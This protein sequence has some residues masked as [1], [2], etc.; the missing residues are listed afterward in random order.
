MIGIRGRRKEDG[1]KGADHVRLGTG[2]MHDT[3]NRDVRQRTGT[4][5][6]KQRRK[7]GESGR[8]TRNRDV[9]QGT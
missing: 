5:D 4:G 3:R 7:T 6:K 9:G 2:D 8:E 1:R